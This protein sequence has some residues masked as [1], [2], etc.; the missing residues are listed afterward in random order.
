MT[1]S[2]A[3]LAEEIR[4][5]LVERFHAAIRV[6]EVA[7]GKSVRVFQLHKPRNRHL[8]DVRRVAALPAHRIIDGIA[9]VTPELLLAQKV[10]GAAART[11]TAKGLTDLADIR[12]LLIQ[13]PALK[14]EHGPVETL[15]G[16]MAAEE[17]ARA[18]W[19]DIITQEILPDEDDFE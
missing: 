15:L 8:V 9:V 18:M 6:R 7:D 2:P 10:V 17:R 1:T 16:E 3:E 13:F 12:R 11:Q 4:G 14:T 19:A 5:F